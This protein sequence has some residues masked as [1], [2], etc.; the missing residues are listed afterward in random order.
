MKAMC[1]TFTASTSLVLNIVTFI[2]VEPGHTL[3][4]E[5]GLRRK[6]PHEADMTPEYRTENVCSPTNVIKSPTNVS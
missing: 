2:M 4:N 1:L 6:A 5:G 3:T